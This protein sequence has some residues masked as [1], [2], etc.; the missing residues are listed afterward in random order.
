MPVLGIQGLIPE[1]IPVF[2]GIGVLPSKKSDFDQKFPNI[3]FLSK[4]MNI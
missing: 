3:N 1:S 2:I 4:Y